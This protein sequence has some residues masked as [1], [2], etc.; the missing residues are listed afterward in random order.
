MG[1]AITHSQAPLGTNAGNLLS[2]L[3]PTPMRLEVAFVTSAKTLGMKPS[4]L[5][6]GIDTKKPRI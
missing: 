3:G 2:G 5:F 6:L 4:S 1:S